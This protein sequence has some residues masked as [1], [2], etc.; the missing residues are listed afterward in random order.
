MSIRHVRQVIFVK[1]FNAF[2]FFSHTRMAS[3]DFSLK[4]DMTIRTV[5]VRIIRMR[6]A[7]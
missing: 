2:R 5:I 1:P 6:I 3:D 7:A 4:E